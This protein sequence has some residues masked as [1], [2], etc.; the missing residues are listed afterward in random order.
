M[1]GNAPAKAA[2]R[3]EGT[4]TPSEQNRP[5]DRVAAPLLSGP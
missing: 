1:I 4:V 3:L 2:K 5:S